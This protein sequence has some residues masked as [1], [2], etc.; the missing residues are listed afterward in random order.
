MIGYS[1]RLET[2]QGG[3]AH[4]IAEGYGTASYAACGQKASGITVTA[5]Q[6]CQACLRAVSEKEAAA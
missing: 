6:P 4:I 1:F 5:G 2:R 3:L